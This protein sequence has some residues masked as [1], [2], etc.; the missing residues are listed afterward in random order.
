MR[1]FQRK[2]KK[3]NVLNIYLMAMQ[4]SSCFHAEL[5]EPRIVLQD[6][7]E[8]KVIPW[9][10]LR[11]CFLKSLVTEVHRPPHAS[12]KVSSHVWYALRRG[13]K[14]P[15]VF[16][17]FGEQEWLGIVCYVTPTPGTAGLGL[18][19]LTLRVDAYFT[20]FLARVAMTVYK[21]PC[22][23]AAQKKQTAKLII[24]EI[25]LYPVHF[26]KKKRHMQY[27]HF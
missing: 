25:V 5:L 21:G 10:L 27:L 6:R 22:H 13:L 18:D 12:L 19:P 2:T 23:T 4:K 20:R 3:F 8:C 1:L 26:K 9:A 15:P 7:V 17:S 16:S 11:F 14:R 24:Y